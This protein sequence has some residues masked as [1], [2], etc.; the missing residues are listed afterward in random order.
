MHVTPFILIMITF[1]Y[2]SQSFTVILK[3]LKHLI[4]DT[5][6]YDLAHIVCLQ[7][8]LIITYI[9]VIIKFQHLYPV[10]LSRALI[11]Y[12]VQEAVSLNYFLYNCT[13]K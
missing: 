2:F 7:R 13:R 8:V 5:S 6:F 11:S 4:Y 3:I 9:H 12:I 1:F 10:S